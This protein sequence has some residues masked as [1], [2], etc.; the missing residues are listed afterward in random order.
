MDRFGLS[1][2]EPFTPT[3]QDR[4]GLAL[5]RDAGMADWLEG[6]I[7]DERFAENLSTV[8]AGLPRDGSNQSYYEGTQGNR[9]TIDWD[10]V[11]GS[12]RAIRES[13]SS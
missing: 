9:A 13:R 3:L 12:L 11:I 2:A 5:A 6:R 4:M 8:W 10:T 1:G 7:S